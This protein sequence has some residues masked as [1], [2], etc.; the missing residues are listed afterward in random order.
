V[1]LAI[2]L[3]RAFLR[4]GLGALFVWAG[5]MKLRDPSAFI[6]EVGNYRLLPALAP[7]LGTTL[8]TIEI[9]AGLALVLSRGTWRSAAALLVVAMMVV[10]TIAVGSAWLRGIDVRCGCFG[11]GGGPIGPL[12]V[13]R[14][15]GLLAASLIVLVSRRD[16]T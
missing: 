11:T 15:V 6:D 10:F 1:K 16:D 8:P 4:I 3:L 12:T 13:A 2:T 9:S 7:L 5:V 14:D